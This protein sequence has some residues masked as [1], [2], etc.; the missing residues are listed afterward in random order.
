MSAG[1]T[2]AGARYGPSKHSSPRARTPPAVSAKAAPAEIVY[3]A[4]PPVLVEAALQRE[5]GSYL[6]ETGAL[7]AVLARRRVRLLSLAAARWLLLL[8]TA[9]A[10]SFF[11]VTRYRNG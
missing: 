5:Q 1:S 8:L 4:S 10:K 3:N 6:T 9:D 7:A 11:G 2:P